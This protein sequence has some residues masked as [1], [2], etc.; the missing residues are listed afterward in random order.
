MASG[1]DAHPPPPVV[2]DE[3]YRERRF[4]VLVE[5]ARALRL[6][7]LVGLA[8]L[9]MHSELVHGVFRVFRHARRDVRLELHPHGRRRDGHAR[10]A[11]A[12]VGVSH[13][14]PAPAAP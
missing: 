10:A 14:A 13:R 6:Q 12:A 11:G 2:Q 7:L 3:V 5:E 8:G 1:E 4:P 9:A